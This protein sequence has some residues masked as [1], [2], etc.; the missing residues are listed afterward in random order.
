[1]TSLLL[2]L[3]VVAAPPARPP[4]A[5][6]QAEGAKGVVAADH[7]L[8]SEVGL[9]VLKAGGDA[10]DAA[11]ATAL[12]LGVLNPQSSGIGGGGFAV[13]WRAKEGKAYALDF[14]ET[15][16]AAAGPDTYTRPGITAEMSRW[17]GL[18]VGV[19]GEVAG[20][21]ELH[22]RWG[23]RPWDSLVAPAA[24]LAGEGYPCGQELA[25]VFVRSGNKLRMA[26]GIA[27][28]FRKPDGSWPKQGEPVVRPGLAKTLQAIGAG[29]PKAFYE[30]PVAA[31]IVKAAA[32][33]GGLLTESDLKAYK[34]KE[35]APL[36]GR[37][38]GRTIYTMPPPSSGGAVL[39]Q[40]LGMLAARKDLPPDAGAPR[41]VALLTEALKHAFADRARWYG[42]PDFTKIPLKKLLAPVALQ[43]RAGQ[44][45]PDK[46]QPSA[47]YGVIAPPPDDSGTSHL[48]IID[49][50]GNAV[51]LTTT[52]NTGFGSLVVAGDTG[53]VLNNEMDDFTTRPG[54]ANA[55]GLI[56]SRRNSVAPGKRPLSS[57]TPTIVVGRVGKSKKTVPILA[58]GGSGGPRIITGTL[59]VLLNVLDHGQAPGQAV[60]APRI[61]HQWLPDTLRV[62][63]GAIVGG[64]APLKAA[65]HTVERQKLKY[66]AI[67]AAIIDP[68][69]R[70]VGA[71][72]PRKHG[73]AAAY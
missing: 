55:F 24:K 59:Q 68:A 60:A 46:T 38:R 19:P 4:A 41:R 10:V 58:V 16:P 57:M 51:A 53:I 62:E 36:Q 13:V 17:G 45:T 7:V 21:G 15:A 9:Q 61:H 22:R 5:A 70:R 27:A 50:A 42:D 35:R 8:A 44:L 32:D 40:V 64:T 47:S 18:A 54:E 11:V 65:G 63:P 30:G 66:G 14:R 1:M 52:V 12:A 71:S 48:S 26:S 34:V 23:R 39:L 73:R 56:Q 29:G 3:T 69:G 33:T 6:P 2:L 37:Y 25:S 43:A 49:A 20:L 31:A 28:L 67:Q 72:D